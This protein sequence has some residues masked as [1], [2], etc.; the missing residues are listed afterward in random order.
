MNLSNRITELRK[1]KGWSQ[2]ELAKNI[3]VSREIVG[4]YERGDA[5][6]SIDIAKRLA[7]AFGVSLDYL[8]GNSENIKDKEMLHRLQE[9]DKMNVEDK[10][11]VYAFLDAF[12]TKTKLESL[13]K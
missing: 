4:R 12:I 2:S 10:K 13:M 6:P 9:I 8:V 11:L 1:Q 7:D 5:M 3:E